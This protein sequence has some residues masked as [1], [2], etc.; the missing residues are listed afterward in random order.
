MYVSLNC[1][2]LYINYYR[3]VPFEYEFENVSAYVVL[4]QGFCLQLPNTLASLRFMNELI[5]YCGSAL[6]KNSTQGS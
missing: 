5:I 1:I 3:A 6:F 4:L 2:Y